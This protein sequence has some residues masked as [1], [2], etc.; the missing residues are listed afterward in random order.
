[1][2]RDGSMPEGSLQISLSAL[3]YRY[4]ANDDEGLL[5]LEV[6]SSPFNNHSP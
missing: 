3:P 5:L 2:I 1:M 6:S 4:P